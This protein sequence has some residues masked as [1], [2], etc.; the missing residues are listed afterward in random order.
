MSG[1]DVAVPRREN[2][3]AAGHRGFSVQTDSTMT[4]ADAAARAVEFVG[5]PEARINLAHATVHLAL[6]PKSNT[7]YE[8]LGRALSDVRERPVGEVPAHLR[9][10]HYRSAGQLGHGVGYAYPHDDPTGWVEQNYLPDTLGD[11]AYYRP[12]A[13]GREAALVD[14]WRRRTGARSGALANPPEVGDGGG[15][16]R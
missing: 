10:A 4:V 7:S 2:K 6:A 14:A 13:H 16:H 9:D 1:L 12:G 5:L 3:I 11:V 8:A 15:G